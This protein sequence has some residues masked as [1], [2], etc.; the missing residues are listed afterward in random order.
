MPNN[1]Q[2]KHC[3][4]CPHRSPMQNAVYKIGRDFAGRRLT[5]EQAIEA[6][7]KAGVRNTKQLVKEAANRQK[8]EAV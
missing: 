5:E 8:V 7:Q 1:C 4:D 6:L 3:Y 2:C